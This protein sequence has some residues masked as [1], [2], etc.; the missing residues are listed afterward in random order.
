MLEQFCIKDFDEI[1]K[2]MEN[3]FPL[4]EF[5][6]KKEQLA[7]FDDNRY[8]IL[9][10]RRNGKIIS[11]AAV[12]HFDEFLFIEHLATMPKYRNQGLGKNI[13]CELIQNDNGIVCLEVEPP[14]DEL[15][16]RRVAFYERCGMCFNSYP[17]IQPSITKGRSP[18]SLFIMT[19]HHTIDELEFN[20]IKN[21]LYKNVYKI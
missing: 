18:V 5:R 2:I 7:L 21:L 17:Y 6:P 10:I 16:N 19:S 8:H 15:T 3:S 4:T 12:W 20:H 13:L 1:Y 9:G 11:F 14:I